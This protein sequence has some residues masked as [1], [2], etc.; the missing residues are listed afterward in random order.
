MALKA[1]ILKYILPI[2]E[3]VVGHDYW[4]GCIASHY[5]NVYYEM[6]PLI[7]SRWYSNSVSAK[8]RT[9]LYYKLAYRLALCIAVLQRIQEKRGMV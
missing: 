1:D 8:R 5:M 3:K 4:I 6:K 9:S 2:S 7:S